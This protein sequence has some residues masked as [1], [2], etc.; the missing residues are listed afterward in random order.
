MNGYFGENGELLFDVD[1]IGV[2]QE[3]VSVEVLLDTG[4]TTGWLA[5]N[6]QDAEALGW[7]MI[8]SQIEMQTARGNEFFSLYEGNIILDKKPLKFLFMWVMVFLKFY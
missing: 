3:T 5:M 7:L 8:A 2:N 6:I 1:L 4:F